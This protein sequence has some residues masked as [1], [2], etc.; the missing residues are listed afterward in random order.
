M[1][2]LFVAEWLD[3]LGLES[4]AQGLWILSCDEAIKLANGKSVALLRFSL[5]PNA[6][7]GTWGLPPLVKA[8]GKSPYD[9]TVSVQLK[10]QKK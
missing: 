6:W 9:L 10:T 7:R 3:S 1:G 5:V 4:L 8:P 2:V